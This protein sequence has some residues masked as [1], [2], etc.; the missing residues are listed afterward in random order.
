MPAEIDRLN[1]QPDRPAFGTTRN[2]FAPVAALEKTGVWMEQPAPPKVL[3]SLETPAG[4]VIRG[5]NLQLYGWLLASEEIVSRQLLIDRMIVDSV[6]YD[7]PRPDVVQTHPDFPGAIKSGFLAGPFPFPKEYGDTLTVTI[8]VTLASGHIERVARDLRILGNAGEIIS[9]YR[10][11]GEIRLETLAEA[12]R[13][14]AEC[15][16]FG[17][18]ESLIAVAA[19]RFPDDVDVLTQYADIE[20]KAASS[21]HESGDEAVRRWQMLQQRFPDSPSLCLAEAKA[22]ITLYRI[23]EAEALLVSIGQQW[24]DVQEAEALYAN[25]PTYSANQSRIEE[26]RPFYVEAQTRWAAFRNRYPDHPV[27]YVLGA[28]VHTACNEFS[29]AEALLL[30]AMDRFPD[31]WEAMARYAAMATMRGDSAEALRRWQTARVRFP[32]MPPGIAWE[33]RAHNEMLTERGPAEERARIPEAPR[34]S[35]SISPAPASG[36]SDREL[37]MMFEGLGSNCDFG[38]VQRHFSAEPLGLLRFASVALDKLIIALDTKFEGIGAPENTIFELRQHPQPEYWLGDNRLNF[39]MHTFIFPEH[40]PTD[41]KKQEVFDKNCRRLA[42]LAEMLVLD[43]ESA[44]KILVFQHHLKIE[45]HEIKALFQAARNYG[46]NTLL[47]VGPSDAK[48]LP[49]SVEI[50]EPGLMRGHLKSFNIPGVGDHLDIENWQKVCRQ[51]YALRQSAREGSPNGV[52]DH[53]HT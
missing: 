14:L 25:L 34:P 33:E 23:S 30:K 16:Q 3:C 5:Q 37:M 11:A 50:V 8:N 18:A 15:G 32:N 53:L 20:T 12:A 9:A 48:H 47:C 52:T 51:A 49:G 40:L 7:L 22:L 28:D 39:L 41:E 35:T 46:P 45:D 31:H 4:F 17:D 19:M 2:D 24:P 13:L 36:L 26:R 21:R 43:L 42:Y 10:E 44:E 27:G 38:A 6:H 1:M 29:L